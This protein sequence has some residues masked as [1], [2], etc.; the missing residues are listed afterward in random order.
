MASPHRRHVGVDR[1]PGSR[2]QEWDARMDWL[3]A[4]RL[5]F[6]Y[7]QDI[8]FEDLRFSLSAGIVALQGPSGSGKTTLLKL[9]N[10][11]LEPSSGSV[12]YVGNSAILILQDDALI[13]WLTGS[14]NLK[15]SPTFDAR[16]VSDAR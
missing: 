3:F 15:I 11:D 6:A 10:H 13:P 9:I 2:K 7:G 12:G 16:R 8:I 5:T 1:I 14:A 4:D